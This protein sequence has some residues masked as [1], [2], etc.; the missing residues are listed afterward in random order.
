MRLL[1]TM[2]IAASL[3]MAAGCATDPQV[4]TSDT[5]LPPPLVP[6]VNLQLPQHTPGSLF[7]SA[8]SD[9]YTDLRAHQVGDIIVVD[10]VDNSSASKKNDTKTERTS[11][12]SASLPYFFGLEKNLR[13]AS[14]GSPTDPLLGAATKTKSDGKTKM[15]RYDTITSSIACTV[16]E[17]L[18]NSNLIIKGSRETLVNGE[19]QH[20]VIQGVVR[21]V[22]VTSS[23][24]VRSNQVAD[25]KIFYTGRGAM[26]DQQ[27]PGWGSRLM[28]TIWP[29]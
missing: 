27:T 23:N 24:T 6:A 29:F 8:R 15:E 25:A 19:T 3:L 18:P 1:A 21:P 7:V 28:D 17:V 4:V 9:F 12:Y 11:E 22:D 26:S 5:P 13:G 16:I 2:T 10:I 14:Q 20:I